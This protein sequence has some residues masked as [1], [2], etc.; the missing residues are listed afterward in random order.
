[1]VLTKW[2]DERLRWDVFV[3]LGFTPRQA[4]QLLWG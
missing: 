2:S 3:A 4:A 1:M